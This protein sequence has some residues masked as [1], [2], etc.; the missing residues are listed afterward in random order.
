MR[1]SRVIS[2]VTLAHHAIALGTKDDLVTQYRVDFTT[3]DKGGC[4]GFGDI[5]KTSYAEAFSVAQAA[6]DALNSI[7]DS[8]NT[9]PK[10]DLAGAIRFARI[11]RP[12]L[13]LFGNTYF[14]QDGSLNLEEYQKGIDLVKGQ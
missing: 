9:D 14:N 12:F 1:L 6:I 10:K 5:L 13:A 7:R 4:K 8:P 2:L 11:A 3:T